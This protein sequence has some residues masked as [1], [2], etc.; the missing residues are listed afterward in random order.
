MVPQLPARYRLRLCR[1]GYKRVRCINRVF[2]DHF[3]V[4]KE[5]A[6]RFLQERAFTCGYGWVGPFECATDC[7]LVLQMS[8]G[9][10]LGEAKLSW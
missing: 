3:V 4:D 5:L 8:L 2:R 9:E 10:T 7:T 1:P 6:Y